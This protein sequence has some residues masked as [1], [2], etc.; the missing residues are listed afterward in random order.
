MATITY[1]QIY[2]FHLIDYV[3]IKVDNIDVDRL[4]NHPELDFKIEVSERTGELSTKRVAQYHFCKII[5]YDSGLV[6]FAGSIH[7]LYNSLNNILAP[8][9]NP[10]NYKGFNGNL[11][12]LKDILIVRIHLLNL[13]QCEPQQLTFQNIELGINT[14]AGIDPMLFL[15]GL[16]Y[17]KGKA[18]EYRFNNNFAQSIHERFIFK[19]YNKSNQYGIN[20]DTLRVELKIIKTEEL[21]Q[22][23]I[24]T[25]ADVN[26]VTLNKAFQLI[27]KRF[28]EVVYFDYTI[29]KKKLTK[30]QKEVLKQYENPR[31]W[32]EK[33]KPNYRHRHKNRLQKIIQN[34]SSNLHQ[35]IR[36]DLIEKCSIINRL[37]ENRKCSIINHSNK[38]LNMLQVPSK[39]TSKKR[40]KK[41]LQKNTRFCKVTGLNISMQ[42]EGSFLLSHTGLK[43][44][45][46]TDKKEFDKVLNKY[47]STKW[48]NANTETKIKELAHNIRNKYNNSRLKFVDTSQ[49]VLFY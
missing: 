47:L 36:V 49:V 43:H 11:F 18:F 34:S 21:K 45:L 39:K 37:S 16:L 25:F 26:T 12:T 9:Y 42:K 15:K 17:H 6:L 4:V 2:A 30:T 48:T 19:I 46:K 1:L 44:Y 8:N 20:V 38:G 22:T 3:K 35:K 7:K 29:N 28:D 24:K 41:T 40:V 10:E 23:G 14:T 27:L 31:F 33:L 13:F 32:L 5:I